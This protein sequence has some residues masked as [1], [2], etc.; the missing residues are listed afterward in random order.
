MKEIL[1][2]VQAVNVLIAK[3]VGFQNKSRTANNHYFLHFNQKIQ[4]VANIV[5]QF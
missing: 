1:L 4:H 3:A 5:K 2:L